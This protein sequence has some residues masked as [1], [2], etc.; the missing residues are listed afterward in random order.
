ME[1]SAREDIN[2]PI[3]WVHERVTD[4]VAFEKVALRRGA[5]IDRRDEGKGFAV[6]AVWQIGFRY[7]G[8]DR[9]VVVEITEVD[10]PNGWSAAVAAGGMSGPMT[11]EL[12]AM[13]KTRTRMIVRASISANTLSARLL[14]QSIKLAKTSVNSRFSSR[15]SNFAADLES[16][17]RDRA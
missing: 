11:V 1:L 12:V 4:Y 7:R 17:Y 5:E 15:I 3:D 14:L 8:R 16:R 9:K 10:A 6:G 13:S 2:A